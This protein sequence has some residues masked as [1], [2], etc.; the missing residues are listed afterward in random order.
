LSRSDPLA[1]YN[2]IL[3]PKVVSIQDHVQNFF[4]SFLEIGHHFPHLICKASAL[5]YR[6]K[7][8]GEV[9]KK[10]FR[11]VNKMLLNRISVTQAKIPDIFL[12]RREFSVTGE[13]FKTGRLMPEKSLHTKIRVERDRV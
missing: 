8:K 5:W 13:I 11:R 3:A 12:H 10:M 1:T 4:F 2:A 7:K 6:Q 9:K